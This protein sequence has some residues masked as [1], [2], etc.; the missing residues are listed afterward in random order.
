MRSA[1]NGLRRA[2]RLVA[3]VVMARA[4]QVLA[5][6]RTPGTAI[7][8]ALGVRCAHNG[9]GCGVPEPPDRSEAIGLVLSGK[10]AVAHFDGAKVSNRR[11][12]LCPS[13]CLTRCTTMTE[14]AVEVS[15]GES[16][17]ARVVV[18]GSFN[19]LHEGHLGLMR[20]ASAKIGVPLEECSFELAV[21]NADK[22]HIDVAEVERRV[23]Q[24]TDRGLR[25]CVTTRPLYIE[26]ARVFQNANFV[27]G[28]V[29]HG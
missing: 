13:T 26:K 11:W 28:T 16:V 10:S 24:F 27:V 7:I 22:G 23:Q 15:V 1:V 3:D 17:E 9:A 25:V 21:K 2:Q 20:S 18:P 6:P 4:V 19:P 29:Q 14:F 8:L 12:V 5:R